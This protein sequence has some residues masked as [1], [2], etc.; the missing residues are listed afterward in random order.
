M[1]HRRDLLKAS[2][3]W[4]AASYGRIFGANQRIRIAGLGVGGRATYLLGL[5]AKAEN[6]EIVA[7]CDVAQN[8]RFAAKQRFAPGGKDYLD[9]REVLER[10]DIDGVVVGAPDHWHVPMT[11]DAVAAGKDVYVEKPISHTIEEGE[12]VEKAV[13]HSKQIVQVG[14]QQRSWPHFLQ[15][16]EVVA[17]GKLG[18]VSLV[19]TSWYQ[20]YV[21]NMQTAPNV[22][23]A[24]IDWKRFLGSAPDQPFDALRCARWRWF[25]DFG[26]GHLTD[27]YSHF[28]DVVQWYLDQYSPL[29]AQAA[30]NRSAIPQFECPDTINAAWDYPGFT[31]VYSGSLNGSLEGG[32]IVFRGHR[33]TMK[34]NRDGFAVYPEGKVQREL[35]HL[36][37]P[38]TAVKSA[39]DG[40]IAHVQNFLDCVRSRQAP[41]A[42]VGPAVSIARAAHLANTAFRKG[43]IWRA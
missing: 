31:V 42:P 21:S 41:N 37:E 15:A 39:A 19:L 33:A 20:D 29:T 13:L 43:T 8:R 9:Y 12:R 34:L 36:P 14:Y 22:D 32:N 35:T 6:T 5:V 16:R 24:N 2:A 38:E 40:T 25:W 1:L 26:G 23:A 3:A 17:G 30:G 27:L 4:T 28:G 11:M 7:V 18:P 10:N